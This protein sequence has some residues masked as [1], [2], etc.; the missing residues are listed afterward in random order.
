MF[1]TD[2]K[3]RIIV[4][5][6]VPLP[7]TSV[8]YL[9]QIHSFNVCNIPFFFFNPEKQSSPQALCAFTHFGQPHFTES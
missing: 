7:K 8:R 6:L 5:L 4:S 1:P 2:D 9:L 3:H